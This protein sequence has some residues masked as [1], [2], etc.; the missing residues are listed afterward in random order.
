MLKLTKLVCVLLV[1]IIG[2]TF[3]LTFPS[4]GAEE[5]TPIDIY[6]PQFKFPTEPIT[7]TF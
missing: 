1:G 5:K 2:L 7:L 4:I 3:G 6:N